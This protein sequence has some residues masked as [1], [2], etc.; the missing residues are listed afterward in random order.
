MQSDIHVAAPHAFARQLADG[1][2]ENFKSIGQTHTEIQKTVIDAAHTDAKLPS[3]E[4]GGSLRVTCHRFDNGLPRRVSGGR[5]CVPVRWRGH[6]S[7]GATDG[8]RS[9]SANCSSYRRA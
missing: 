9:V 3:I 2:L 7:S 5:A 4:S 1:R 8:A 6:Y